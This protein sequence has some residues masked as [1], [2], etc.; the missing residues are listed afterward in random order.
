MANEPVTAID[1]ASVLII[2]DGAAHARHGTL[3]IL[4][5]K[6]HKNVRFAGGAYVFPGGKLDPAD[7]ALEKADNSNMKDAGPKNTGQ[8]IKPEF[9]G[10]RYAALREVF[11]ETGLIIG[12][13]DKQAIGED[14]RKAID[15]GYRASVLKGVI[16]LKDFLQKTQITL[17]MSDCLPFA[18]WITPKAYP[19]RFDTRFFLC[20]A[21][22]GQVPSPDGR[23][24]TE[25]EWMYP[26]TLVE[27]SDGVLMFPTMMNLKKLGQAKSVTEALKLLREREIITVMPEVITGDKIRFRKIPETAGYDD[28]DQSRTRAAIDLEK[29]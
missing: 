19:M 4:M 27:E 21:P 6:R 14:Q 13:I 3:Q 5:V 22:E 20:V 15:A 7:R 9:L 12:T 24:I 26:M 17:D 29:G 28:V 25:V 18:H 1:S 2:R 10:L 23:E 16:S 8:D 11:E